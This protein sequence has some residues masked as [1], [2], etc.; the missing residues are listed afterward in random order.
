MRPGDPDHRK[1]RLDGVL[2]DYLRAR[3]EG[4]TLSQTDLLGR[5]PDLA[6]ELERFFEVSRDSQVQQLM[7]A[8]GRLP[9]DQREAV[10]L[11]YL[12]YLSLAQVARRMGHSEVAVAG[13]LRQGLTWLHELLEGGSAS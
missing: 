3:D 11:K 9:P 5:H 8:L 2:A 6:P 1:R 7:N 12:E 13:L 10:T 4:S